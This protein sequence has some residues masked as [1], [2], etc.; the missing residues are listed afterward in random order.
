MKKYTDYINEKM[1]V[2][3]SIVIAR[4]ANSDLYSAMEHLKK[5][6]ME[7]D[8]IGKHVMKSIE[9]LKDLIE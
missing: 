9:M 3:Y 8:P 5:A 1:L 7:N 4:K 2:P 6:G